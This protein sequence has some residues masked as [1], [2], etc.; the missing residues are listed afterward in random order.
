MLGHTFYDAETPLHI[1]LAS[2]DLVSAK[3][4][5][6]H[7]AS[8]GADTLDGFT[9]LNYATTGEAVEL[10]LSFGADVDALNDLGQSPLEVAIWTGEAVSV[11]ES[12]IAGGADIN[13]PTK[14]DESLL[15]EA[16]SRHAKAVPI[17]LAAGADVNFTNDIDMTALHKAARRN[18]ADV[19]D[20]L[21]QHGADWRAV[22]VLGQTAE[23]IAPADS[24]ARKILEAFRSKQELLEGLSTSWKPSDCK[25]EYGAEQQQEER[26]R[27]QRKM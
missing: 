16:A 3:E 4:L 18:K 9:P 11:I 8:L 19:V 12:L 20:V 26:S 13:K 23:E 21:L 2:G 5:L 7:G 25:E 24:E 6:A 22:T 27:R 17:L 15:M 14:D 1:A 10:L